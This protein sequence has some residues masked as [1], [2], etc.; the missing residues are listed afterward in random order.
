[1]IRELQVVRGERGDNSLLLA[2]SYKVRERASFEL[3]CDNLCW[4]PAKPV[5]KTAPR[6]S[7]DTVVTAKLPSRF[8][9]FLLH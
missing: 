3:K 9:M 5:N 8:M 1:M 7:S 2:P 4:S 6:I